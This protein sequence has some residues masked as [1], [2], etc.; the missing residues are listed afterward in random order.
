MLPMTWCSP[1]ITTRLSKAAV[2]VQLNTK[3]AVT[4]TARKC[5]WWSVETF[6]VA[7]ERRRF[8]R[9]KRASSL[10]AG[11][12][13]RRPAWMT[14]AR[15]YVCCSHQA[16]AGNPEDFAGLMPGHDEACTSDHKA[17]SGHR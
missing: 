6:N 3:A 1:R 9:R 13:E 14:R 12:A 5:D 4:S 17:R 2:D 16:A 7:C 15:L 8:R 11:R 10:A